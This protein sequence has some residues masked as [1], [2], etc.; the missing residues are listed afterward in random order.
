MLNV[1]AW[2]EPPFWLLLAGCG[3]LGLVIGSFLN[4]VILRLPRMMERD[5]RAGAR[6]I[7]ELE[8]VEQPVINLS[9]PGSHCPRC[10]QQIRARDNIPLLSWLLLRGRC[11]HCQTAIP[12]RYPLVEGLS[13]ILSVLVAWQ[14][15]WTVELLPALI[16]TWAL[17]ALSGIDLDHQL[18]PDSIT[19]L[20]IWLGLLLSLIPVFA[21]DPQTAIIGAVAGYLSL[22]SVFHAFR[23][24]TGK[25]GMGY[26]D[27]KLLAALGAWLGWTALP[28]IILLSALVGA[29][30]GI[31]MIL[32]LGRDRQLP[33]PFGPYLAGAGWLALLWGDTLTNAYF[34]LA[35]LA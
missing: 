11:R 5:W 9:Q 15:G 17:I 34:R 8:P 3:L 14:I 33:I 31:L 32:L 1:L 2:P 4:V 25:E 12:I 22:W 28:M 7:L 20:L 24:L 29:I 16:L 6:E 30:A 21:P 26:G 10:Q 13:G 23:L 35:G 19:L 27:F 18:L